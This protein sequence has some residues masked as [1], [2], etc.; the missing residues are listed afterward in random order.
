MFKQKREKFT[1]TT[2]PEKIRQDKPLVQI[3]GKLTPEQLE[4]IAGGFGDGSGSNHNETMVTA[5]E[6]DRI[7]GGTYV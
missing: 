1:V 3:E 4:A 5:A 6:L 2:K 7:K